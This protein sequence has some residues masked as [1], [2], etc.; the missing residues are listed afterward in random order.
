MTTPGLHERVLSRLGPAIVA[1]EPAPGEV[2]RLE[3]LEARY[4]VSRTV[5]REVV[6]VLESMHVVTSRRRV[7][8][9]VL[10]R[11]EWNIFDPRMIRWRLA[12]ADR[13]EQLS[14][15]SQLRT[16][17]EP[18]AAALAARNATPEHCGRLTA[19]VIGMS[20]SA[21]KG[22]LEEYLQHD[23]EF[24]HAVLEGSGNE[25][26]AG[27]T[28]VVA[29]VLAGRTHHHLMPAHPEPEA[30]RL[31]A[32][33]SDAIQAGDPARAEKAMRAIVQEAIEAMEAM[34][35]EPGKAPEGRTV[36]GKPRAG[37]VP[38]PHVTRRR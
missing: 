27:L 38:R 33:V 1:G 32:E 20:V 10:P 36:G 14:S 23:I 19:A 24:H 22:D 13:M 3:Q 5:V 28:Q 7:G 26:F 4:G 16:A 30:L 18:V 8:V 2:L 17:V 37:D 11:T 25:M 35:A 34:A 29:E 15:L 21:R 9:T 6:K 12:G 31:H